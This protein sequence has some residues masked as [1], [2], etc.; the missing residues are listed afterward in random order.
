MA[1][2]EDE[3]VADGP[4]PAQK[5]AG[6]I[7]RRAVATEDIS[8][9]GRLVPH[10]RGGAPG[11]EDEELS[12]RGAARG[13]RPMKES[14]TKLLDKLEEP[15]PDDE[16]APAEAAGD[17]KAPDE[18]KPDE[19]APAPTEIDDLRVEF[20]RVS[21]ANRELIQ[22][23]EQL[24]AAPQRGEPTAREK[25]LAEAETSY[26]DDS[27]GAI[28]KLVASVLGVEPDHKDVD[29]EL[30]LLYA[31]LTSREL[32]VPLEAAHKAAR[33]AARARQMLARDKRER[34]AES[35]QQQKR[36]STDDDTRKADSAASYIANRLP[37]MKDESGKAFADEFPLLMGL[38]EE[39]DGMTPQMLLWKAIEREH[40][41]GTID[42]A[43]LGEEKALRTVAR[44]IED[45][46]EGIGNKV[47]GVKN[48]KND[49]AKREAAPSA[50]QAS[51]KRQGTAARTITNARSSVAPA[52]PPA[53]KPVAPAAN[54]RPKFRNKR[55]EQDWALRHLPD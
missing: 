54:E 49:T 48:S 41:A 43:K 21:S 33:D 42:Y 53:K 45:H 16:E 14:V 34:K 13:Q 50:E 18:A 36:A 27:V 8:A 31:D 11:I 25:M 32:D 44:M 2:I 17:Q 29:Q 40:K 6:F 1:E 19:E 12:A 26:L 5:G 28:R 3:V 20:E 9:D 39:L 38:S 15:D 22:R 4:A 7:A 23:V 24:E 35:E 37:S 30:K 52:T 47:A 46:Y 10:K 51:Q 55:E